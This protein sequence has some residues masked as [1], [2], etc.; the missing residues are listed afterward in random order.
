MPQIPKWIGDT[1]ETVFS[2]KIPLVTITETKYIH[3]QLKQIRFEGNFD[4]IAFR[5]GQ[6]VAIRVDDRNY[7]NYTP[8]FFDK[9]RGICD[10][11]FH[12]H[13]KGPG[14][15]LAARLSEGDT[16][17]MSTPRGKYLYQADRDYHFFF[18][19]ETTLGLFRNLKD[20]VNEEGQN[21]IGVLELD[22]DM[23]DVPDQLGLMVDTVCRTASHGAQAVDYINGLDP[24]LW[25]LWKRGAF[26]LMGNATSIQHVRKALKQRGV[27]S[28]QI[29]TQPY[30]AEGKIGL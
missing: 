17:R 3:Q 10:I 11:L 12:L 6:P 24:V 19:D 26:Y 1:V 8:S 27:S 2:S 25:D 28:S 7:R 18:G 23:K 14:S 5:A 16:L 13:G 30:W 29:I 21:Y 15:A 9:Q 22:D 4:H 20:L